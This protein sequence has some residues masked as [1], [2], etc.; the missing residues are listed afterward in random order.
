LINVGN[1]QSI[2]IKSDPPASAADR[3]FLGYS[4]ND[5]AYYCCRVCSATLVVAVVASVVSAAASAATIALKK[6]AG[7]AKQGDSDQRKTNVFHCH[8]HLSQLQR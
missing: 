5:A 1:D 6:A 3:F 2:Q 8:L 4:V 7:G